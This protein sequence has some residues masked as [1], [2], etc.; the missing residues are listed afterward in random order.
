MPLAVVEVE[1][2]K[3]EHVGG[4]EPQVA[5]ADVDP[6]ALVAHPKPA[7]SNGVGSSGRNRA[8]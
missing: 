5:D 8:L 3:L 7:L 6:L 2:C 1:L 4:T